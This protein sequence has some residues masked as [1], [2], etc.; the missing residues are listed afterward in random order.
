MSP[1]GSVRVQRLWKRFR[2]DD[3]GSYARAE[4]RRLRGWMRRDPNDG[5]TWALQDIDFEIAPGETVG[6]VGVNGSGKSTL[7]KMIAG[8][9]YPT[10][11]S[12]EA[13]GRMSAMIDVRA[14]IHPELTGRENILL[15]ARML[16]LSSRE[17]RERFDEIVDFA[18]LDHALDRQVKHYSSGMGVRLGFSIAS[19]ID[20]A[21]LIVDEA[22]SVGDAVFRRKCLGR[23]RDVVDSGATLLYVSHGLE[24]VQGMCSR[25]IWLEG[26]R[27]RMDA[28][29][30]ETLAEYRRSLAESMV[31][32]GSDIAVAASRVQ[33][34]D[35]SGR[36]VRTG[37]A[38]DVDIALIAARPV[39]AAAV[40]LGIS[41]GEGEP[42]LL[43]SG[44]VDL[45]AGPS[46]WRFGFDQVPLA[47]GPY[48]TWLGIAGH[49]GHALLSWRPVGPL[50]VRGPEM[51]PSPKG[52]ARVAPVWVGTSVDRV[53][54]DLPTDAEAD[55]L[56]DPDA[57]DT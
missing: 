31:A 44:T 16:G 12:A 49:D 29:V 41:Q 17:T 51:H 43:C 11:G 57:Q 28:T 8:V 20:P 32:E 47:R 5:W 33:A 56:G 25:A 24:S 53:D 22:L 1:D 21:I 37:E 15:Y 35:G 54:V 9:M 3:V 14:G 4:W 19:H 48:R 27:V 18:G 2:E 45:P 42:V 46:T 39:P 50:Q 13:S 7:L 30:D 6:L 40:T 23:M 26:G 38:V 52:V 36:A 10:V 55:E 34:R